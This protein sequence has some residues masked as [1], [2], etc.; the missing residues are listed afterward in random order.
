MQ[1]ACRTGIY[2]KTALSASTRGS[3]G[4]QSANADVI[5]AK[6]GENNVAPVRPHD[7]VPVVSFNGPF[8]PDRLGARGRNSAE[9]AGLS[10]TRMEQAAVRACLPA[11]P[12]MQKKHLP[13]AAL[14]II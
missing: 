14:P 12:A 10:E 4:R 7:N 3:N 8:R 11:M 6:A 13:S 2:G 9:S 1:K 5:S